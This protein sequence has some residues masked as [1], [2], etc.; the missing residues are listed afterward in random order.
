MNKIGM[1]FCIS[2]IFFNQVII[3]MENDGSSEGYIPTYGLKAIREHWRGHEQEA[4]ESIK[5]A[6]SQPGKV[7]VKV[8]TAQGLTLGSFNAAGLGK[9]VT[10]I[11]KKSCALPFDEFIKLISDGKEVTLETKSDNESD[12]TTVEIKNHE[13][14]ETDADPLI[15]KD[16]HNLTSDK[17]K[18]KCCRCCC[19]LQ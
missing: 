7:Q 6:K 13:G 12:E 16:S 3:G 5:M 4:L 11:D 18:K 9:V 19:L 14:D 17:P 2:I 1:V 8:C 15:D 10:R